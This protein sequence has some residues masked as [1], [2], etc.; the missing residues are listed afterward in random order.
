M[1]NEQEAFLP[2][3]SCLQFQAKGNSKDSRSDYTRD[4]N[5]LGVGFCGVFYPQYNGQHELEVAATNARGQRFI[6]LKSPQGFL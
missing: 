6:G 1:K 3:H 5:S 2:D 4:R